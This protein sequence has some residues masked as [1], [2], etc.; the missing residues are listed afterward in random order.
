MNQKLVVK[1]EIQEGEHTYTFSMP[2]GSPVGN[3]YNA[4]WQCLQAITDMAKQSVDKAAPV[5]MTAEQLQD[6]I[7]KANGD[8][9]GSPQ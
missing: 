3:A 8:Q 2:Y 7:N 6:S 1:I 4:A 9:N 5:E